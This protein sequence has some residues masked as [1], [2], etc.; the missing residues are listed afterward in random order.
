[1]ASSPSIMGGTPGRRRV[2]SF[3]GQGTAG[4][5][6]R[7]LCRKHNVARDVPRAT[8]CFQTDCTNEQLVLLAVRQVQTEDGLA[9]IDEYFLHADAHAPA[10]AVRNADAS[11][12]HEARAT[13]RIEARRADAAPAEARGNERRERHVTILQHERE[14]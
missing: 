8:L 13:L 10:A 9:L 1:M 11:A 2:R 5:R 12:G 14:G 7:G 3:G 4:G 6:N